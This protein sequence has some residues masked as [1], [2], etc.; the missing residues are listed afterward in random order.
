MAKMPKLSAK[1]AAL[2]SKL[3]KTGGLGAKTL[4]QR[5]AV[6]KEHTKA[7]ASANTVKKARDLVGKHTQTISP[8]GSTYQ[9]SKKQAVSRLKRGGL[10]KG[11]ALK[12]TSKRSYGKGINPTSSKPRKCK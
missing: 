8:N 9:L 2:M 5:I 11:T 12:L 10:M 1:P 3:Q 7:K 4:G 6:R